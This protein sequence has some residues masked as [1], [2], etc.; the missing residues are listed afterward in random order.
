MSNK[1]RVRPHYQI[2]KSAIQQTEMQSLSLR[3]RNLEYFQSAFMEM[4]DKKEKD[5][6]EA[7]RK[8][9]QNAKIVLLCLASAFFGYFI[10][11]LA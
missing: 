11:T 3:V 5:E 6:E 2:Y 10:T 1:Y 8:F 7:F 9:E 4:Q